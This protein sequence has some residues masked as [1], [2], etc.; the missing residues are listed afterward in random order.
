MEEKQS[1]KT[2]FGKKTLSLEKLKL[3]KM[4]LKQLKKPQLRL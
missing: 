3:K 1:L 2:I 4:L